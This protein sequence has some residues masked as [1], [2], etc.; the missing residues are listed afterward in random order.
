MVSLDTSA[1]LCPELVF[2]L[3]TKMLNIEKKKS[4]KQKV[5]FLKF[6]RYLLGGIG[7]Y[8]EILLVVLN[9][10]VLLSSSR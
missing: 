10:K 6:G 2:L 9:R 4:N 3:T 7:Q 5:T 8:L 1:C